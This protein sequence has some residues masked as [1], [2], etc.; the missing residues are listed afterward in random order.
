MPFRLQALGCVGRT[1]TSDLQLMRLARCRFSTSPFQYATT[2]SC[3]QVVWCKGQ[4]LN[5][6]SPKRH[7]VTARCHTITASLAQHGGRWRNRTPLTHHQ[8]TVF[9]TVCQPFSGTFQTWRIVL[10]SNQFNL[11][12]VRF[13]KPL[14]Y[15]PAHD[16]WCRR[17]DSNPYA[18]ALP[19]ES[20]VSANSTTSAKLWCP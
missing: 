15:R 4:G 5:L 17:R 18:F 20:S 8:T 6:L 19:F 14:R 10:E 16:P 2:L 1:R 13:S 12:V 11:S 9:R 7:G 3:W